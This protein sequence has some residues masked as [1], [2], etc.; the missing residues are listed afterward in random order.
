MTKS[1][2]YTGFESNVDI[3]EAEDNKILSNPFGTYKNKLQ[4]LDVYFCYNSKKLGD[5]EVEAKIAKNRFIKTEPRKGY[6][7]GYKTKLYI[8]CKKR[9]F[10]KELW[11]DGLLTE[12]DEVAKAVKTVFDP[13]TEIKKMFKEEQEKKLNEVNYL[14]ERYSEEYQDALSSYYQEGII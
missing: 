5:I 9:N 12:K 11:A 14:T 13:L 8:N 1:T 7:E 6:Y 3:F 10:R 4:F 2:Q